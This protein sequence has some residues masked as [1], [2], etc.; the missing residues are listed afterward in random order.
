M[1]LFDAVFWRQFWALF[2]KNW[3]VMSK[4]P[5][6]N[7]V[8]CFIGPIAYGVFLAVAQLFLTK[9]SNF[10]IGDPAPVSSL[11]SQF[12][13]SL[14]LFWAD[15]SN[16]T[17]SPSPSDIMSRVTS[18]FSDKQLRV[19]HQLDSPDDFA[20]ACPQNFNDFSECFAAVSFNF[21]NS[22]GLNYTIFVDIGLSHINVVS[23][24]S[25]Y[26]KRVLPL[27]WAIDSAIIELGTNATTPTPL[28]WPFT[29]ETNK[30]QFT[31]IRLNYVRGLR[32]LLVLALFICYVGIAYQLPGSF[33]GE[34]AN[35]LTSHLQ[36]MGLRDSARIISW[37]LSIT[38]AYLPA[39]VIV[40]LVWHFRI[41]TGTHV[42]IVLLVHLLFGLS[43]ASWSLFVAA[44]FENSPQL[45]AVAS[46]F[47]SIL[48]AIL[49]Q[50]FGHASSG[51]AFIFSIIFPPGFYVFAIRAI[52]GFEA[53]QIPTNLL[54]RDP[55]RQLALLPLIIAAIID[56][57]LWPYLAVVWERKL[58][59]ARNPKAASRGGWFWKRKRDDLHNPQKP[60][61][62]VAISVRNLKKTFKA[63]WWKRSKQDVTAVADLS[64][65]IPKHGIY[66][67][68][69]SN[70]AGKSTSLSILAG[71][72]GR[73]AGTVAFEDGT[74]H[75]PHGSLGIVPQKNV[76]FPELTCLQTVKVWKAIKQAK[77]SRG[78]SEDLVQ[79]LKDCDLGRKINANASTLSGG[80]KRKLQLAVGLVGGS[81]I[82]LVDECT[83]GVD[84]LSRR[85]LWKTL[86]SVRHERTI[87]FTTHFLDEADLLADNIAILAAPGKLVA[88]GSPVTLKTS[89]GEGFKVDVTLQESSSPEKPLTNSGHDILNVIRT[90][91]P[92]SYM[93]S[94]TSS[95][96]SYHLK[97]RDPAT[98]QRILER[99]EHDRSELSI[100]TYDL[101]STSMEDI[102]LKLM[103]D[104]GEGL[105]DEIITEEKDSESLGAGDSATESDGSRILKLTSGRRRSPLA[106]A[107]TIF[108]KRCIIARR[109]WLTPLLTVV[110][111]VA[112][113]CVPL[114]FLDN[115]AE[116]CVKQF[117]ETF[118]VPMFL[119]SSGE[120]LI[121]EIASAG[122][123][124]VLSSPPGVVD[125]LGNVTV[126][127]ST[128]DIQDNATFV[129]DIRA[130]FQN[131][132]L[133]GV[134]IDENTGDSL[135]AWEAS[136]P[137]TL[138]PS[139]LNLATN[140]LY[141]RAL[142]STGRSTGT[143]NLILAN[144]QNFPPVDGGTLLALKWTAF[145]GACMGAFPAFFALYVSQE[146][147]TSVQTMQL[148]NGLADPIGLW[149]GHLLFD[150]LISVLISSIIIIVF[151]V[152]KPG[153]FHGLGFFWLVLTL[154][155]IAGALFSY[156]VSL[157][158]QSPLA[159]FAIV[160]GY[161]VIMFIIYTAGYL[162]T[163]TYAKTSQAGSIITI[164][165]FTVSLASPVASPLRASFVSVNLFSLL[166]DGNTV[167]T[168]SL[169]GTMT[170]FGGPIVYLIG[171]SI[172]LFAI[173]VW[174]DSGTKFRRSRYGAKS[175]QNA[176]T[177]HAVVDSDVSSF[178]D[179][180]VEAENVES[181]ED[182]LRVIHVTKAFKGSKT[183]AV[184]DVSFGVSQDTILALL[185]PNGA[186]KT[187]TFNVIRG[188]IVP[189]EGDV[190]IQGTSV[191][192]HPRTARLS[193][194]VC[195]QFTAIDPQLTVREHLMVY[196]RLKGLLRGQEL[197][198][199]IDILLE[200]TVL[201]P[202]AD[203]LA[204]K[205]SGGN[206]R[207]LSLAIAL[208]GNPSVILIDEFSTG[209][210]A[211]M[212]RDMWRTLKNVSIGKAVV[213]TTHSME[214]ASAL[215][216][217][218]GIIASRMLAVGTTES[219]AKRYPIYEVH[220]SCRNREEVVTAQNLMSRIP[221]A[222]MA[223]DVA[224]RFEVPIDM[225][226]G[227]R[228]LAGL[229]KILTQQSDVFE[230]TVERVSLESVFLKVIRA[231]DIQEE[232]FSRKRGVLARIC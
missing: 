208:I 70:G 113:S 53:H 110:I 145:F 128:Q 173:L 11:Q 180:K 62:G 112:G 186:G 144:L 133:G 30:E 115:R 86:I 71:L 147:R 209:I 175:E 73:T 132:S 206:Q 197:N 155:G 218:V 210:D 159:A 2:V 202:Y 129:S 225:Q 4:H 127:L 101:H 72:L 114:F 223:E 140:I 66:V 87:V 67:L 189:D 126:G 46:T 199:N 59:N 117:D 98:V 49:A 188:D 217:K 58:Y 108:H 12:D 207:K 111:A 134:S 74:E 109:S 193:L 212:K 148:S 22:E 158:A 119:P 68:L 21:A 44:P 153:Q 10:G 181:A 107:L 150:G 156:C 214:E 221:G 55:D 39:W 42:L 213:I 170:K 16:G 216:N 52:A 5:I 32:A 92:D 174:F 50:A 80:Q 43:L 124:S 154:Y 69:G 27:Q 105:Q 28:E 176:V 224:T 138:G 135:V 161:Q 31:K 1:A 211:K 191:I 102:F 177:E 196:G 34:R 94:F 51:A 163:L 200:C 48:F 116:T 85:A 122:D 17:F 47:L 142:N 100:A 77:G 192:R 91:A 25:D 130:N 118:P 65:D 54:K 78:A 166:C 35:L 33:M 3:I 95:T 20:N 120:Q 90:M 81:D 198:E 160:A 136:P 219:L 165:H 60:P 45:A 171:Y 76:L 6:L 131:F 41:F 168:T 232:D 89:L 84:P 18:G 178:D 9:P 230:Y 149:L 8:R 151:A 125:T 123:A 38:L 182:P 36:A 97:L 83:S 29:Q 24:T 7:L 106:Q 88:E 26:E 104:H 229:F 205:L 56:V 141:N 152:T 164:I 15:G 79:L 146:R 93:E 61:E 37:H 40:A 195:P 215:A 183:K 204:T 227:D 121:L 23:H 185:G 19:V 194:G 137:G 99:L 14:S 139:V 187:S 201:T 169:L 203:R 82:L 184:S 179:V 57:F 231:N 222:Q 96:A 75:P 64:L 157:V 103:K 228:S 13:G 226:A 63:P 167:V 162:L 172:V 220:F 190:L 143:P